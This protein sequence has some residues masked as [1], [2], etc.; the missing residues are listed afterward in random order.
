MGVG[1]GCERFDTE[2]FGVLPFHMTARRLRALRYRCAGAALTHLK[3]R[4]C[5][6]NA[7][8]R[9]IPSPAC[10]ES[11]E[12]MGVDCAVTCAAYR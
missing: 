11:Q 7:S 3:V 1:S 8:I 2:P 4:T 6:L 5:L 12:R 9:N 10:Q